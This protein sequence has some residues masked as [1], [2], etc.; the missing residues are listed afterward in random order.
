MKEI[1]SSFAWAQNKIKLQQ[2]IVK[3]KVETNTE[4]TEYNEKLV[5]KWYI[6][7]AGKTLGKIEK[8]ADEDPDQTPKE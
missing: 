3:A 6:K 8:N 4:G 5:Y 2:A 1:K 7:L